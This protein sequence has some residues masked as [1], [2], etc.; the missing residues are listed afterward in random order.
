M[1]V[2]SGYGKMPLFI[3][4]HKRFTEIQHIHSAYIIK[5]QYLSSYLESVFIAFYLPGSQIDTAV[6][7][8]HLIKHN[9]RVAENSFFTFKSLYVF[10]G[11]LF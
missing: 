9:I 7:G 2:L 5:R 11:L 3:C 6:I 8:Q 4:E 10:A 1:I